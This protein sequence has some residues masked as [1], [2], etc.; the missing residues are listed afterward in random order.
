M[1]AVD[2]AAALGATRPPR[3]TLRGLTWRVRC[4]SHD[5]RH[6]SFDI[7]E[8]LDGRVLFI[9]R[10]GCSQAELIDALRERRLWSLS[11]SRSPVHGSRSFEGLPP[12]KGPRDTGLCCLK[13]FDCEHWQQ[14]KRLWLLGELHKNLVESC[15]ELIEKLERADQTV[16]PETLREGLEF[17]I[18][19]C[20]IAVPGLDEETLAQAIDLTVAKFTRSE[21]AA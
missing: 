5:D 14:F 6:A 13:W 10:A 17:A 3:Q 11:C 4:P 15:R 1:N 19:F 2:I 8:T 16:T 18:P 9:C 21:Q 7:T 20:A 12:H